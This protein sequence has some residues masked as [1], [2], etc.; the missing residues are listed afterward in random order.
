M[1]ARVY[2]RTWR[3]AAVVEPHVLQR[4]RTVELLREGA[5]IEVV[6]SS[7]SIATLMTWMR[8]QERSSWPHLLLIEM[9]PLVDGERDRAAV[10]AL[11]KA[12][13]RVVLVSSLAPR[14]S[15]RA[16]MNTEF[17][18]VV[19]KA[20][21]EDTLLNSIAEVLVGEQYI[22]ELAKS[23]LAPDPRAP[24]LSL[25]EAKVFELYVAGNPIAAV[26]DSIG[27]KEDTARK[28]LTR[29]KKKY[30]ALGRQ[31]NSKLDLARLAW[32][33]GLLG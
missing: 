16:L 32:E 10:T 17:D 28:Y 20:D 31:A 23:A 15:A 24:Q 7:D 9:L 4:L 19:S 8:G 29:V 6:H 2:P 3:R 27:V 1:R 11:R 14:G 22:T 21:T 25:Q 5:G 33:D 12:G 30:I 18:G 13:V 26:A